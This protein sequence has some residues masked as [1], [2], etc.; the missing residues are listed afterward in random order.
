[1]TSAIYADNLTTAHVFI[2]HSFATDMSQ[3]DLIARGIYTEQNERCVVAQ[4]RCCSNKQHQRI[5][6][7]S[8]IAFTKIH[9]Q[10]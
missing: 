3:M 7:T 10:T 2:P 5:L 1:M 9:H 8:H 6:Q 4:N